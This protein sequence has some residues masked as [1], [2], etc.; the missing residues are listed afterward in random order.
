M[1]LHIVMVITMT[2]LLSSC[3]ED[4]GS[5]TRRGTPSTTNQGLNTTETVASNIHRNRGEAV[6][7]YGQEIT[8]TFSGNLPAGYRIVPDLDIDTEGHLNVV[9]VEK[10]GRPS[11]LCGHLPELNGIKARISDCRV[12]NST[13]YLWDGFSN[14]ASGEGQW[15]LVAMIG[16]GKEIWLDTKSR[17]VWSE[18]RSAV[19]WCRASGNE[20]VSHDGVSIDCV[21]LGLGESVCTESNFAGLNGD[22]KWRLPT[23]NDYLQADIDGLRFIYS[24]SKVPV[25]FFWTATLD[26]KNA[27]RAWTYVFPQGTLAA[28]EMKTTQYVRCIGTPR[29]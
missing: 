7:S 28:E 26:S 21:A 18:E 16:T 23:R 10:Q 12:K 22:I 20:Q 24:D 6:L 3:N 19:N 9:T 2:L 25:R 17:M 15:Q 27:A 29:L 4:V 11:T 13:S 14:G 1:H 8:Q 5:S